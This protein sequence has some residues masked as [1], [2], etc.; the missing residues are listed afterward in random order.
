MKGLGIIGAGVMGTALLKGLLTKGIVS[1]DEVLAIEPIEE[2]RNQV[3]KELGIAFTDDY[4]E[5]AAKCDTILIAVKPQM[6]KNVLPLLGKVVKSEHLVISIAAG[7]VLGLLEDNMTAAKVV[8]VMPNTPA[9]FGC[10]ISAYALGTKVKTEDIATIESVLGAVG[11]FIRVE[12]SQMDAVTAVSGSGPAYVFKFIEA[13][14]EAGVMMGLTYAQS[15]KLTVETILGSAQMLKSSEKHPAQLKNE[16]TSP[17]GTTA[18]A[19]C[20]LETGAFAGIIIQA[21]EAAAIR[22]KQLGEAAKK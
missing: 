5:L 4:K 17:A 2:R 6:I 3:S 7:V 14:I 19:L 16:V 22:S 11:Q 8:R 12:E 1:G 9:Q 21:V 13:M 10:G 20:E 18:A 15:R